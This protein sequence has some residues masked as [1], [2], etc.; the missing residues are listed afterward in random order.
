MAPASMLEDYKSP[1]YFLF[2]INSFFSFFAIYK[3]IAPQTSGAIS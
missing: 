3:K 1:H 2:Q